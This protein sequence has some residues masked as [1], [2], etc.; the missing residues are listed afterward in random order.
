MWNVQFEKVAAGP[1]EGEANGCGAV[2]AG[3]PDSFEA[4]LPM[5]PRAMFVLPWPDD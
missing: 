1:G 2:R 5:L 4:M 3:G